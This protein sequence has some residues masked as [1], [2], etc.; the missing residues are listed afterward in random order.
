MSLPP[1]TLLKFVLRERLPILN[2]AQDGCLCRLYATNLGQ[3]GAKVFLD[4]G[5]GSPYLLGTYPDLE[6]MERALY[7]QGITIDGRTIA[8][9]LFGQLTLMGKAAAV[10]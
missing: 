9:R 7:S 6:H 8:A 2:V 1:L 4:T 5:R 10:V 3:D